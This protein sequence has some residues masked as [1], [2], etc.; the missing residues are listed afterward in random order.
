MNFMFI[1]VITVIIL[2]FFLIA[3]IRQNYYKNLEDTLLNQLQT[4]TDLYVRYFSATTLSDN[5][6]NNVDTFWKQV[7]AQVEIIGMNGRVLMNS[8]GVIDDPAAGMGDVQA[9]LRGEKGVWVGRFSPEAEK[10]MAASCPIVVAGEQVGVLRFVASLKEVDLEIRNVAGRYLSFG[11]LVILISGLVSIIL[12]NTITEPLKQITRAAEEMARGNFK[13]KSPYRS[14]DEIGRLSGTLNYL[15]SEILKKDELKND[16]ISSV[17]HELRTPLTSIKGWAVTLKQGF[18]NREFLE[19]GLDIIEKESDRLARMVEELLDFSRFVSGKITL[20]KEKVNIAGL[21]EHLRIQL[22]PRAERE[23]IDFQIK[24]NGGDT[25][26]LYTDENR[27]KQVFI[28]LLDNAFKFTAPGGRV[29]LTA[30]YGDGC[31]CFYIEDNGCGIP[32]EELPR[33]KEKFYKGKSS[34]SQSGIGLSISD[35]IVRLMKGKLEISSEVGKGTRVAV[36]L[37][38]KSED[39]GGA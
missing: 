21:L 26:F 11:G 30:L 3:N 2:E 29:S 10:V 25:P 14:K 39:N 4:S 28:N 34:K 12:A 9:A 16:F 19:D 38:L 35:E 18:E 27:L 37:P 24:F 36:Y 31:Y 20:K 1:I 22:A 8:Q 17:S 7:T 32:E 33:V 15:A 13:V 6:L 23:E 5:I